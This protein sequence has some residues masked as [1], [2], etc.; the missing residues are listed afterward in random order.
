MYARQFRFFFVVLALKLPR[1]HV[2]YVVMEMKKINRE[3]G[4]SGE[5]IQT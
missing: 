1:I 5:K 2:G 3:K 4:Y